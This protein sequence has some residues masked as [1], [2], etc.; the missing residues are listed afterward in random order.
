MT[1]QNETPGHPCKLSGLQIHQLSTNAKQDKRYSTIYFPPKSDW[2]ENRAKGK[3]THE[4]YN[5]C[6]Q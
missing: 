1:E 6:K 5:Q 2:R 3:G 4:E